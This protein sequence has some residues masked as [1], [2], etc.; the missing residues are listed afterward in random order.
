[1]CYLV[2]DVFQLPLVLIRKP[3][4]REPRVL[5]VRRFAAGAALAAC[6]LASAGGAA[7]AAPHS[8]FYVDGSTAWCSD[9]TR[10]GSRHEPFCTIGAAAVR[11]SAGVTVKI[12]AGI[13]RERVVVEA[14]GT[15]AKPI[16]FSPV[17]GATVVITGQK[18]GFS[19][20]GG[21]WI[22]INGFTVNHT[23][24]YGISVSHASHITLSN[25]RVRYAGQPWRGH[26]KYGI[27]L[28]DVTRSLVIGNTVDHNTNAG[29]ALVDGSA[30]NEITGNHSFDNAKLF[31]RG[32]SGIRLYAS[33]GNTITRNVSHDNE[34]SGIELDRSDANLVS[35]NVSY[36]NGDHG[37]DVTSGSRQTRILA[38]T[39]YGNVTAGINF[40][41]G[42]IGATVANNIS[43]QNGVNSPRTAS[44]IR[45]D[46][47]SVPGTSV[48]YDLVHVD[49]DGDLLLIWNSKGYRSLAEFQLRTG[50]ELHGFDVDPRWKDRAAGNFHLAPRSPAIDSATSAVRR[51]PRA[52]IDGTRRT[53]DPA[54]PNTGVGPRLYDDRGA[55]EYR[56]RR[57]Q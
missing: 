24:E 30:Q 42:S 9:S 54:T 32:A 21:S 36:R 56:P 34:D 15:G 17:R 43:V 18:N 23:A 12:A 19:I 35:N 13:Y 2:H 45:V 16:V 27:R 1:V 52:D 57:N 39:I 46:A 8:T 11:A 49:G 38:N 51:Q 53:D 25:N 5:G 48:D 40:E 6:V 41:G 22:H 28:R 50:Q 10:S 26:A 47:A 31:E 20:N 29:I 14:S 4:S 55:F 44:N 3:P 33:P 37:I 7:S